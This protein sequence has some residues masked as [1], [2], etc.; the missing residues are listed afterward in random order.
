[1]DSNVLVDKE[2]VGFNKNERSPENT[3]LLFFYS[4]K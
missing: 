3:E 2:I 1:V 4:F